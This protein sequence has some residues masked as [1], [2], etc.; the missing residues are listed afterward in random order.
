MTVVAPPADG[1]LFIGRW[2]APGAEKPVEFKSDGTIDDSSDQW[3][4]V[5]ADSVPRSAGQREPVP[6]VVEFTSEHFPTE[7]RSAAMQD[8]PPTSDRLGRSIFASVAL[9][10]SVSATCG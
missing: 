5:S 1:D 8:V 4:W 6:P 3:Q 9:A 2:M 7:T 10:A